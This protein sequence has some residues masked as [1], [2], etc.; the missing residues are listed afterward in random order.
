MVEVFN[1]YLL[2]N[3]GILWFY[4]DKC[5]MMKLLRVYYCKVCKVCILKR[6]Y[7]CFVIGICVG[8]YNQWY[9]VVLMFYVIIVGFGGV[10]LIVCYLSMLYWLEVV[11]MDFLFFVVI[12]RGL[13]GVMKGYIVIMIVYF[14][15]VLFI[16]FFGLLY[17]IFQLIIVIKGVML[18]EFVKN[19][20]IRN[21]KLINVNFVE[22]FGNFWFLNFIFLMMIMFFLENDGIMWKG[23]KLDYN[24]NYQGFDVEQK[25]QCKIWLFKI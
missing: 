20:L 15:I 10:V 8:Y 9:F 22:V 21:N 5:D 19:V 11:W 1:G 18:Y 6:D 25:V 17:F 12:Y 14:Y 3:G 23:I 13:F 24:S 7:Y 16:G 2:D 4:C